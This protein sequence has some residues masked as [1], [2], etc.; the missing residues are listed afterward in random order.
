MHI[1]KNALSFAMPSR[2]DENGRLPIGC[3]QGFPNGGSSV[4]YMNPEA[5]L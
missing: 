1:R 2:R 5:V 3:G 4:E